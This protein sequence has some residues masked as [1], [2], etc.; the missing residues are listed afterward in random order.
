MKKLLLLSLSVLLAIS[1][2]K[3][4]NNVPSTG[5]GT[6]GG[7]GTEGGSGGDGGSGG[8]NG[9]GNTAVVNFT[10]VKFK[11]ALLEHGNSI[12]EEGIS[13]IDINEDKEIQVSEAAAYTGKIDVNKKEITDLTGIE[14]FTKLTKL[15]CASNKLT[16]LDLSENTELT[17]LDC[18]FNPI[19]SLDLSKNNALLELYCGGENKLESLDV[20]NNN[21][22]TN[23]LCIDTN[24][25]SLDLSKNKKLNTI[26]CSRNKLTSLILDADDNNSLTE[27][28]CA[29]NDL[30]SLDLSNFKKLSNLNVVGNELTSLNVA[31]GN[32]RNFTYF[33]SRNNTNLTCVTIDAGYDPDTNKQWYHDRQ[34]KF[35]TA[36]K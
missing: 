17:Y 31:N 23:F 1:C 26:S 5:G 36:C 33:T 11:N 3:D 6:T 14:A 4:E 30:V 32:N 2:S 28:N 19:G 34:T 22:L 13:K 29:T 20:S 24:I 21:L 15:Y 35:S 16:S 18:T 25:V 7:G 10:D 27:L 12:K 8:G 9:G